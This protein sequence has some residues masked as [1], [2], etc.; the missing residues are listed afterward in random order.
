MLDFRSIRQN[1]AAVFAKIAKGLLFL[2]CGT[3]VCGRRAD[4]FGVTH[5]ADCIHVVEHVPLS[6]SATALEENRW[7]VLEEE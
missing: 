3:V 7:L 4:S 2:C 5:I 6:S 1:P